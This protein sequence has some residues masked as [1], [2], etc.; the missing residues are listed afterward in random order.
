[1]AEEASNTEKALQHVATAQ[2]SLSTGDVET[3]QSSMEQALALAPRDPSVLTAFGSMLADVGNPEKAV[4]TLRQAVRMEPAAGFEKY[5]YLGQLLG[6]TQEADDAFSTGIEIL[7][8]LG[9]S[10][11][12]SASDQQIAEISATLSSAMCSLAELRISRADDLAAASSDCI[13]LL[14]QA[15]QVAP[16]N[17]EPLQVRASLQYELGDIT[18]ALRLLRE[19]MSKWWLPQHVGDTEAGE[20]AHASAHPV[21]GGG[22]AAQSAVHGVH[23]QQ[24]READPPEDCSLC[25]PSYEFR[26]ECCKLLLELDDS[27]EVV[28]EVLETLLCEQDDVPHTWHLL[29]LAHYAGQNFQ[30]ARE[31][32][33]YG[34]KVIDKVGK[35]GD[36]EMMGMFL[37]LQQCLAEVP[38]TDVGAE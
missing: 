6:P 21:A 17:P 34:L 2:E 25:T 32:L 4:I 16:A 30:E 35:Q 18:G 28:L 27:T 36:A 8:S 24:N 31:A 10:L 19:S 5:M 13:S 3:A 15:S 37:E 7:K 23:S 9:H 33:E 22:S 29:A 26:V 38:L 11:G 12:D 20:G 1:M 14:E